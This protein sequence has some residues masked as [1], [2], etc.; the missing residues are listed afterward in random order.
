M[1]IKILRNLRFLAR[2]DLALSG[3][4]GDDT[5]SNFCQLFCLQVKDQQALEAWMNKKTD[6]CMSSSIQNVCLKLMGL[7][8]LRMVD[9]NVR[10][11]AVCF[12]I[13]ADKCTDV[14]S[15]EQFTICLR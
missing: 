9:K 12:S 15:K 13:M 8:I 10:D 14:A 1:F 2:Q 4:H 11:D 6:N 7:N 5:E 3:N